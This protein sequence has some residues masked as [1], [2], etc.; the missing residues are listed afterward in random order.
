MSGGPSRAD[1]AVYPAYA[2]GIETMGLIESRAPAGSANGRGV[3][4]A[5]CSAL[6]AGLRAL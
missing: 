4:I 5:S 1:P 2:L 6:L 3:A